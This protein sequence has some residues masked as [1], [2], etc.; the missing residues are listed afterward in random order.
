MGIGAESAHQEEA[1]AAVAA[2]YSD[3][4]LSNALVYGKEGES[5]QIENGLAVRPGEYGIVGG[6]QQMSFG[7]PFLTMPSDKDSPNKK[8]EL[9][10][11]IEEAQPS[12]LAG[13]TFD[14][15]GM[16]RSIEQLNVFF[17]ERCQD[18]LFGNSKDLETELEALSEEADE[19]GLKT[20]LEKLNQQ[21]EGSVKYPMKNES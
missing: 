10:N 21:L 18:I 12:E 17:L 1:I 8:E 20:V 4:E 2:I 16:E 14:L 15:E 7:N 19:M 5:Y 6:E 3:A 9:W 11:L 13:F